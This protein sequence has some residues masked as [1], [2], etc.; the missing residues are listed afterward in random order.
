[1]IRYADFDTDWGAA[2]IAWS[3]FGVCMVVLPGRAK[4][5]LKRAVTSDYPSAKEGGPQEAAESIKQVRA[6]LAGELTGF[7]ASIDLN[8]ASPFQV[9]VYDA[10]M[11]IPYGETW[12]Y[13]RV[14]AEAGCPGAARAVGAA[15]SKNRLPLMVPCH[16]VVRADGS[17][18]GFSGPGGTSL[19]VKLLDLEKSVMAAIAGN[20]KISGFIL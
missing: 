3:E 16:R 4:S 1:M 17:P 5:A 13:G 10:L 14:A 6:Y 15:N 11:K 20:K 7:S 12:S 9:R 8:W 18:G 2:A 19:K